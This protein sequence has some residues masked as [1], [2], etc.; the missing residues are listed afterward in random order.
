[1]SLQAK[2]YS[3]TCPVLLAKSA[4]LGW[5]Q[6]SP[7]LTKSCP[8]RINGAARRTSLKHISSQWQSTRL[9]HPLLL[10][11]ILPGISRVPSRCSLHT[12]SPSHRHDALEARGVSSC[13]SEL[14]W[15]AQ[16]HRGAAKLSVSSMPSLRVQISKN[17]VVFF[18]S[19]QVSHISMLTPSWLLG[20]LDEGAGAETEGSSLVPVRALGVQSNPPGQQDCKPIRNKTFGPSSRREWSVG[21]CCVCNALGYRVTPGFIYKPTGTLWLLVLLWFHRWD[22]KPM[23]GL[24][25]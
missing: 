3:I 13:L 25:H 10:G 24:R 22:P 15:V 19:H 17:P 2:T 14:C 18:E 8:S 21:S 5:N 23:G 7:K 20:H 1:M 12:P 11:F 4:S 16:S 9:K 6:R